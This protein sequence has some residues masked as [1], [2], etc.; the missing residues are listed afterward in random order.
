MAVKTTGARAITRAI[1]KCKDHDQ[2]LKFRQKY[3]GRPIYNASEMSVYVGDNPYKNAHQAW[4]EKTEQKEREDLSSNPN[5]QRGVEREPFIRQQFISENEHWLKFTYKQ[6]DIYIVD[7]KE[8]VLGATLDLE[9]VVIAENPW[10]IPIGAH[11][12]IEFKSVK[13]TPQTFNNGTWRNSPPVYYTEQQYAQLMATGYTADFL[14][15]EFEREDEDGVLSYSS[16]TYEPIIVDQQNLLDDPSVNAL[17]KRLCTFAQ[18]VDK[19]VAPDKNVQGTDVEITF[20]AGISSLSSFYENAEEVKNAVTLAV[21]SFK[22]M[23][24]SEDNEKEGKNARA[25]LNKA[26]K[27]IE[28][29]RLEVCREFDKP[30]EIFNAKCKEI[31]K[32]ID[33]AIKSIDDQL[34]AIEV[35]RIAQKKAQI[36]GI[37]LAQVNDAFVYQNSLKEVFEQCGGVTYDV[38]WENRT[39]RDSEITKAIQDQID[40]FKQDFDTIGTF[41]T[42]N[43]LYNAMLMTYKRTRSISDAIKVK[44]DLEETRRVALAAQQERASEKVIRE[45]K[46]IVEQPI[47]P[48]S[49]QLYTIGFEVLHVNKNQ[50]AELSTY[51]KNRGISY[52]RTSVEKE[53]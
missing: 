43:E 1:I 44:T 24:V 10:N 7:I 9:A 52:R 17:H 34:S 39:F 22:E 30:K 29:K 51:L 32:V 38:R 36:E 14:V 46:P 41:K 31:V 49:E 26:R 18:C 35:S 42:D 4:L 2:W 11:V 28:D 15:A 33:D 3:L 19:K 13:V 40:K 45:E 8:Y 27:S 50:L 25:R 23:E 6:Y 12:I 53:N 5:I 21:Q 37:I 20:K 48:K 16:K 47:Q